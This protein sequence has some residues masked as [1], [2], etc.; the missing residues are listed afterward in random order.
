MLIMT[1]FI[2]QLNF[3]NHH[4]W[5]HLAWETYSCLQN[6]KITTSALSSTKKKCSE[7]FQLWK[8]KTMKITEFNSL[9]LYRQCQWTRTYQLAPVKTRWVLLLA[10][11]FITQYAHFLR[12]NCLKLRLHEQI[13][14][15]FLMRSYMKASSLLY[16]YIWLKILNT[17]HQILLVNV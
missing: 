15:F 7:F 14:R 17:L 8:T 4:I 3:Q 6:S 5:S 2:T 10:N 9:I 12:G 16:L 1:V 11:S 13:Q